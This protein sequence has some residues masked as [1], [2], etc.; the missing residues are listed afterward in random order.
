MIFEF[1]NLGSIKQAEIEM[2]NLTVICGKNNTGKTYLSYALWAVLGSSDLMYV[3]RNLDFVHGINKS[4]LAEKLNNGQT[5]E[6][7]I[8]LLEDDIKNFYLNG[9]KEYSSQLHTVFSSN[10]AYFLE[11]EITINKQTIQFDFSKRLSGNLNGSKDW[12]LSWEKAENSFFIQ[13]KLKKENHRLSTENI[14][15]AFQ[16]IINPFTKQ[17]SFLLT[18]QRDSIQL[19]YAEIDKN[20][21]DLISKLRQTN[22][23]N[24]LEKNTSRF[25]KPIQENIDFAR[26]VPT[27]V[28]KTDSF[29]K[30]EYP[31]LLIEIEKMLGVE[32]HV[33]NG[34]IFIKEMQ[35]GQL[36][37]IFM[38]STSV[39]AL[40]HLHFWLKH[41]AQKGDLLMI[42]EPE[43]NL[44]PEN[45]IKMARL[46]AKL[47]NAGIKVWITTHSDY[48]V[49]ELNNLIM[50]GNVSN[51]AELLEEYKKEYSEHDILKAEDVRAYI[52]YNLPEGGA[53]VKKVEIDKNGM[54]ESTFDETIDK[55]ND[56]SRNLALNI[57]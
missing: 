5:V 33:D 40:V 10:R 57:D 42:D 38:A 13:I 4:E 19:F 47:I 14:E 46:F 24:L 34:G 28:V 18:A 52:A 41:Q 25:P 29:L 8:R 32:F 6:M 20:R 26:D 35:S 44:H 23:I 30:T 11:T 22:D 39:R 53:T 49:K 9:I 12:I 51:R 27:Q 36:I 1:K 54:V 55:M 2:G 21:S 45:Q 50:L 3:M 48:I 56:I 7:D 17:Y 37:P 15:T 16:Y 31:E 43:L